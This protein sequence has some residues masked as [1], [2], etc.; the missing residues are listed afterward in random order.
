MAA[1][2]DPILLRRHAL[3]AHFMAGDR[4]AASAA[5]PHAEAGPPPRLRATW[6]LGAAG[7]PLCG[8][9]LDP[10]EPAP[11]QAG[12]AHAAGLCATDAAPAARRPGKLAVTVGKMVRRVIQLAIS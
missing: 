8:W 10:V 7:R 12:G 2:L 6:Q 9:S 3:P 4:S 5:G 1:H 11:A